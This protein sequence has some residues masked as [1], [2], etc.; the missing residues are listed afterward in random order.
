M[1]TILQS[2]IWSKLERWKSSIRWCL[3][4][5]PETQNIVV[6]KYHLVL[7]YATTTNDFRLWCVMKS[8]L[9]IWTSDDQLND[10]TEKQLQLL[11]LSH[12]SRVRLCATPEMAAHQAPP[13]LGLS[14][15]EHW[16]GLPFPSP[17]HESEK[18]KGSR[19]VVSDSQ[20]PHGL[21]PT[22]L[23]HLWDSPG[24]STGVGCHCL[25]RSGSKALPKVKFILKKG[26]GHCLVVCCPSDPLQLSEFQWNH[27]IWELCPENWW[28]ALETAMPAASFGQQKGPSCYTWQSPT[29]CHTTNASKVEW[30]GLQSFASSAIFTWP[31]TTTASSSILTTFCRE[32]TSTTSRMLSKSLFNPK[33]RFLHYRN[34]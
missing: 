14:R 4:S 31:L 7:F 3:I 5:W 20:Q 27:Y 29:T 15:Q 1:L 21:Q 23:L 28:E 34:K 25:L 9:Y 22:R 17:M 8:G 18:W 11:L 32:N 24:K 12:F 6:L 16:S 30:I 19:S 2:T 10:W 33:H 13:S 26:N